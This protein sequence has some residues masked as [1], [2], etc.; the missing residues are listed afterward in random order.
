MRQMHIR[1]THLFNISPLS[2]TSQ[3]SRYQRGKTN[4]DFTEA[5]D[6]EWQWHQLG[7]MQVYTS[8]QRDN[9]TQPSVS[10]HLG[11]KSKIRIIYTAWKSVYLQFLYRISWNY[12][13]HDH[14]TVKLLEPVAMVTALLSVVTF[15]GE[16][17]VILLCP[18]REEEYC[19]DHV[20]VCQWAYISGTT[21]R[22]LTNFLYI[23]KLSMT[24][25]QWNC[26]FWWC[27]LDY[28]ERMFLWMASPFLQ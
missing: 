11:N 6:S 9:A 17:H 10:K 7:Y 12:I 26:P 8:L 13:S 16:L 3:V 22:R 21:C 4:L 5:R 23:T 27:I 18:C 19:N 2:G 28:V 15:V 20:N 24:V 1:Y 25:I 14:C